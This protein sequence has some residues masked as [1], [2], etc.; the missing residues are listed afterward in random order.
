MAKIVVAGGGI[1]GMAAALVLAED[2]H[3]IVL[4]DRDPGP[5]PAD[6]E[7]AWRWER[8]SVAQFRMAHLLL[9]GGYRIVA[10]EMPAVAARLI[11]AGGL[12]WNPVEAALAGVPGATARPD[13][14]RFTAVTGR[15]ST[16]E[17]A[18]AA[19][20]AETSGV[21]VRRGVVL[22]GFVPGASASPGVPH[23]AGV[24]IAGGEEITGDLVVDATGRRSATGEWLT[25]IGAQPVPETAE[26][27]GFTYT[28][29]FFRSADGSVP[30]LRTAGLTPCGSISLLT[31]PSD[32]GTW[33]TT[34][35][36]AS[37]DAALRR[38]RDPAT[39]ARVWRAFP[40][41]AHWLDGEPISDMA[42]MSGVVDRSRRF[43]VDG[44][45]VATGVLTIADAHSCTNPSVGRGIT[46]GLMHTIV[47]RDAVR[48]HV[49]DP[50]A[51]A[52]A[53]D[54]GTDTV[55]RPWHEGTAALD[56][57]RMT[58]VR[59][60]IDGVIV[61]PSPE[62]AVSAAMVRAAQTDED[63]G[64]WFAEMLTC[65]ALPAEVLSRP[66]AFERVIELAGDAPPPDPY[67]PDRTRLL[68]LI[69]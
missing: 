23:V 30:D 46:I 33:S 20:L 2:G 55:V 18:F 68:E 24:R 29:R 12:R 13:D 38:V 63:V 26:D 54:A 66:G 11:A 19:T 69:A 28:G 9:P 52:L 15:R 5:V 43:V 36:T 17:W 65:L 35:Y 50:V 48:D 1:C 25:A 21:E 31:I 45:P 16:L 61:E 27:F 56:R 10:D 39:F 67:G 4:L 8:R 53:F 32:N 58:E 51:L 60:A 3:E 22:D 37:D 34:I 49:A 59:A 41:H 47:M 7:A 14:D 62:A 44:A 57:A 6:V 40:D 42:T 64:R